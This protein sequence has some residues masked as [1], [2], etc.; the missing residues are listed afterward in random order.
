MAAAALLIAACGAGPGADPASSSAPLASAT[1]AGTYRGTTTL[2]RGRFTWTSPVEVRVENPAP[3][4]VRVPVR[5]MCPSV[6]HIDFVPPEALV[7]VLSEPG[8]WSF[9]LPSGEQVRL[10]SVHPRFAPDGRTL[11]IT[12]RGSVEGMDLEWTF[13][14]TR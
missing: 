13:A 2:T 14:G 10:G 11:T 12:F 9:S 3:G 1:W 8:A 5:E 4:I 7:I 6:D